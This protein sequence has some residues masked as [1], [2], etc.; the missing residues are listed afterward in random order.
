MSRNNSVDVVSKTSTDRDWG[1]HAK[2]L[3]PACPVFLYHLYHKGDP[4]V[5]AGSELHLFSLLN[6][7][8]QCWPSVFKLKLDKTVLFLPSAEV[9]ISLT[10]LQVLWSLPAV[11]SSSVIFLVRAAVNHLLTVH[12][13]FK[14]A[15]FQSQTPSRVYLESGLLSLWLIRPVSMLKF[16]NY[17]MHWKSRILLEW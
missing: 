7:R 16:T 2:Q 6:R 5:S 11:S 1:Q 15:S 3:G 12:P 14:P 4:I 9:W 13:F 17:Y 8:I 10:P